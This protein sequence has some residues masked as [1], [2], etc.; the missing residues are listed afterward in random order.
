MQDKLE[1]CGGFAA[2]FQVRA[3]DHGFSPGLGKCIAHPGNG[4]GGFCQRLVR[5]RQRLL[6]LRLGASFRGQSLF[7]IQAGF[8]CGSSFLLG[9]LPGNGQ[10][11][12]CIQAGLLG[13]LPG[14][15]QCVFGSQ[16]RL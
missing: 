14:N 2:T 9:L 11:L 4:V 10:C 12:F 6:D 5:R 1:P 7:C 16:A 8:G 3:H 13:L 15:G